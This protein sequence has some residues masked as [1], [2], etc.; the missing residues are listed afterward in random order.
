VFQPPPPSLQLHL[1]S[2]NNLL[3]PSMK[4][5]DLLA[6]FG[7]VSWASGVSAATRAEE[8]GGRYTHHL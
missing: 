8:D 3:Q 1:P 2:T 4:G 5:L 7:T 6:S